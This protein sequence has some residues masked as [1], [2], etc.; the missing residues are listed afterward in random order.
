MAPLKV[1]GAG[2]G[3]TG[4][5]SLRAALNMLG[6]S[7]HHMREMLFT[8]DG[9]PEIFQEA[10]E[11]P[12][13]DIDWDKVYE[14]YDAAVDWPTAEFVEPLLKKYPDA[15]VLLTYRDPDSWYKSVSNTLNPM[16]NSVMKDSNVEY[17]NRL[18]SMV[19]TIAMDGAIADTERFKDEETIKRKYM[20]HIE[21]VKKFV[22]AEKLLVL[23]LGE[24]WD[25]LCAFLDKPVPSEPYP[26]TNSTEDMKK[27]AENKDAML[28]RMRQFS[29]K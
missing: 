25:R 17:L 5:E 8:R 6:Y 23:E 18:H 19:S 27:M 3:R 20:E 21:W 10:Y 1:I 22:P 29:R 4:T 24:G 11:H 26:R 7:T 13:H 15:K 14:G 16:A 12:D 2:Y 9:Y 28:E